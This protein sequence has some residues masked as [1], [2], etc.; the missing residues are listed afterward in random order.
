MGFQGPIGEVT[1]CPLV[2]WNVGLARLAGTRTVIEGGRLIATTALF[3]ALIVLLAVVLAVA[4]LALVQRLAPRTPAP[5]PGAQHRHRHDL[6]GPLR[7]V[8]RDDRVLALSRVAA[9]RRGS[10]DGGERGRP[11]ALILYTIAVLD[12]LSTA[13]CVWGRTL[14]SWCCA[15]WVGAR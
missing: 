6:R 13:T 11:V 7:H 4:G 12:Y 9:V 8:R 14:S 15:I 2:C 1:G 5:P 3:G 10:E